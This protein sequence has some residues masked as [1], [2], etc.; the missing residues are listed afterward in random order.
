[1]YKMNFFNKY[2]FKYGAIYILML[3]AMQLTQNLFPSLYTISNESGSVTQTSLFALY[4]P[5]FFA[6]IPAIFI[7]MDLRKHSK[8][9]F[10][11]P[12]LT[13]RIHLVKYTYL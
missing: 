3:I 7:L 5:Q 6:L 2:I 4:Q 11:I 8:I 10:F 12:L 9:A 13:I 1:M